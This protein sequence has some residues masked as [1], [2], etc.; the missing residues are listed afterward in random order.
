MQ[1]VLGVLLVISGL[2]AADL[3]AKEL[4]T[5]QAATQREVLS[6]FT[7]ARTLLTLSAEA[8][9]RVEEVNADVGDRIDAKRPLV[10]LDDTF[11]KLDLRA[12]SAETQRLE[13]DVRH[14]RKQVKRF[15][16]LLKQKSSSESQ[17]DDAQR[18]LD[19][20]RSQIASLKVQNEK[21]R[22]KKKRHCI[23]APDGWHLV[24][25]HVEQG[26][27]INSGEPVVRV[28]DYSR[29]L[30]PFALSLPEFQTLQGLGEKLALF[31]PELGQKMVAKI[32]RVSPSFDEASHKIY[33]EL[34]IAVDAG[35]AR[36]GLRAELTLDLPARSGA[37]VLPVGAVSERYEEHWLK[38]ADGSDI[39]VVFLGRAKNREG[40]WARV[41]AP[42]VKPGDQFVMAGE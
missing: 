35:T 1:K 5:A 3:H 42:G 29:L 36:G 27:W 28:G 14:Y 17:L 20:A 31:L 2:I 13:V 7:R 39:R 6:G 15:S 41:T 21:L 30:V 34:E 19:S 38:R 23:N 33:V 26:Q 37:V 12:N 4:V 40:E 10:C 24:E 25:R 11:I 16:Q 32:E 22:E 8:S 18:N 9:G